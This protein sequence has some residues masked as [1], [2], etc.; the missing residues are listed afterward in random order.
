MFIK[1]AEEICK[2]SGDRVNLID[3]GCHTGRVSA[4]FVACLPGGKNVFSIGIDPI[5]HAPVF[6]FSYYEQVGIKNGPP[7]EMPFYH[8]E[9]PMC[10]SLLRMTTNITHDIRERDK[11][12]YAERKFE[13]LLN[14]SSVHV[15]PLSEIIE[16]YA[17][18][19][20]VIHFLKIDTQG[21]DMDVFRSLGLYIH[22][23]LF[24]QM[25][26]VSSGSKDVVLYEGQGIYE[27]DRSIVEGFGFEVFAETDYGKLG[28][29]PEVDVV[30]LNRALMKNLTG[31]K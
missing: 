13:R 22:N 15:V 14:I 31:G 20:S 30:Y 10:N 6:N 9:D 16:K 23:C 5:L 28:A 27:E 29:S 2:L 11:K 26:S 3:V 1:I 24:L 17:L 4:D 19:N 7:S 21:C 18:Q 25:E 8:Y 12:W